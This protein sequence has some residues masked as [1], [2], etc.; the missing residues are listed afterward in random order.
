[1]LL[2][3]ADFFQNKLFRKILS[4]ILLECQT[5]WIQ[6]RPDVLLGLIWVQTVCK[7]YQQT[8]LVGNEFKRVWSFQG[9]IVFVLSSLEF[10][11]PLISVVLILFHFV[12]FA[13]ITFSSCGVWSFSK[14]SRNR[15]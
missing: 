1:M 14:S 9:Y 3:S 10:F 6:I 15:F 7:S 4:G 11:N 2:S 12:S 8:A 13:F 5:V